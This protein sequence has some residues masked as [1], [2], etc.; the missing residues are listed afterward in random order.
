MGKKSGLPFL[1]ISLH[2]SRNFNFGYLTCL[3]F[4]TLNVAIA[5]AVVAMVVSKTKDQNGNVY[6]RN[7][8]LGD[9]IT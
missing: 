8:I 1:A 6:T 2:I 5:T 7:D 3:E 9:N 4:Q